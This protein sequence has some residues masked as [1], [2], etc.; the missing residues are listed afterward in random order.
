M[1]QFRS[2]RQTGFMLMEALFVIVIAAMVMGGYAQYREREIRATAKSGYASQLKE[3]QAGVQAYM[4]TNYAAL[5]GNNPVA[6]FVAPMNP[7]IAEL[8][9]ANIL[10]NG[11]NQGLLGGQ[12]VIELQRLPAGCVAP[13]CDI[14]SVIRGTQPILVPGTNTP[15]MTMANKVASEV[16]A[17]GA[18]S[19]PNTPAVFT[20]RNGA[21]TVANP[22][23]VA[24]VVAV[25]GG[26]N[27]SQWAQYCPRSGC[28]FTGDINMGGNNINNIGNLAA[29][30]GTINTFNAGAITTNSLNSQTITNSG[31][32]NSASVNA[33]NFGGGTFSGHHTGTANLNGSFSG[34]FVGN[35]TGNADTATYA[36]TAGFANN[37]SNATTANTSN[38]S[39][40]SGSVHC[41]N[42]TGASYV[43]CSGPVPPP[44]PPS[45]PSKPFTT[46]IQCGIGNNS[47]NTCYNDVWAS[48]NL[49]SYGISRSQVYMM[50]YT[51][52]FQ[53][54][55]GCGADDWAACGGSIGVNNGQIYLTVNSYDITA[56]VTVS[57]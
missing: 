10:R 46:T 18:V 31:A 7:T 43:V 56:S 33:A 13:A 14:Q 22:T 51:I 50:S 32:I 9:A 8:V 23:G 3:I 41:S 36:T 16:G 55:N 49:G 44:P 24:G 42:V 35:L 27:S 52:T 1:A 19:D 48:L 29:N 47:V 30:S 45:G 28:T 34:S 38:Y 26:Y 12:L 53:N 21:W 40:S 37:A 39:S 20:G 6:G 4:A 5:V 57:W 11:T 2:R 15:D 54:N 17:D 25:R